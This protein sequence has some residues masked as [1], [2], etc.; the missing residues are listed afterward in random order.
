MEYFEY[1][2]NTT[3]I[4][5]EYFKYYRNTTGILSEYFKYYRNTTGILTEYF[6]YYRNTTGI[7]PEYFEAKMETRFNLASAI[8]S[9]EWS[10]VAKEIKSYSKQSHKQMKWIHIL[11]NTLAI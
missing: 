7:L 3:R 10:N 6:E 5:P 1:Y 4:L 11:R 2:R 9:K 8:G